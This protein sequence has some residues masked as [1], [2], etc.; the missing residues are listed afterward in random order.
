MTKPVLRLWKAETGKAFSI[1]SGHCASVHLPPSLHSFWGRPDRGSQWTEE[2]DGKMDRNAGSGEPVSLVGKN[3][4]P[5]QLGMF[6][7]YS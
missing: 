7:I 3:S 6:I 1:F 5:Q 2:K 4:A